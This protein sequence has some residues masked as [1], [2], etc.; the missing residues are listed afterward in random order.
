MPPRAREP[1]SVPRASA[2]GY[3]TRSNSQT[4]QEPV[5]ESPQLC[6]FPAAVPVGQREPGAKR[7]IITESA[8]QP[9]TVNPSVSSTS[10]RDA[11]QLQAAVAA[12]A[13]REAANEAA[14][15]VANDAATLDPFG[16]E[17]FDHLRETYTQ[18]QS[19]NAGGMD[20]GE[21]GELAG[22]GGPSGYLNE[23]SE[24]EEVAGPAAPPRVR[25]GRRRRQRHRNAA[26]RHPPEET[27]A[28]CPVTA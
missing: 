15:E 5:D 28:R 27:P 3:G 24:E 2:H 9:A 1:S 19:G 18:P 6:G 23:S 16:E 20:S 13:A 26:R 21:R 22:G 4:P 7:R 11:A 10:R 12:D 25:P 14:L 8:N 17:S